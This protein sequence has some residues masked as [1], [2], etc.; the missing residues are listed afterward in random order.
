MSDHHL[1]LWQSFVFSVMSYMACSLWFHITKVS[2]NR[3]PCLWVLHTKQLRKCRENGMITAVASVTPTRPFNK[4]KSCICHGCF[5]QLMTTH[6]EKHMLDRTTVG[7]TTQPGTEEIFWVSWRDKNLKHQRSK[8][9]GNNAQTNN[10]A[11][12][13]EVNTPS[14]VQDATGTRT[15]QPEKKALL[16]R[17][18]YSIF[19]V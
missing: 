5:W 19:F 18:N 9:R 12:P 7:P 11:R 8:S 10:K 3:T 13:H 17:F 4:K 6:D 14:H 15:H 2:A 16:N 1:H